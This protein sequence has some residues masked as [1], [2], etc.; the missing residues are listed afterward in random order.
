MS[1]KVF[2]LIE[3]V[4]LGGLVVFVMYIG[5][6]FKGRD[7]APTLQP[8]ATP[9]PV[10]T[11]K[12]A[13]TLTATSD[14]PAETTIPSPT[15]TTP[16]ITQPAGL[17]AFESNRDGNSEIY[18]VDAGNAFPI[19]LTDNPA[20]D[21]APLWSPDGSR[22]AFFSTRT[23]WLEI[24]A[25]NADGSNLKQ[26]TKT[27]GTNTAYSYPLSW[28]P[29]GERILALRGRVWQ[30]GQQPRPGSLD[31]IR[32]NGSGATTLYQNKDTY[33]W[34]PSWSPD[35][36]YVAL[37]M[38][39]P[40][41]E[42][43]LYLGRPE[44]TPFSLNRFTSNSCYNYTWSPDSKLTCYAGDRLAIVNPDGTGG[45]SLISF[46][47][48]YP[49]AILWL[50][51]GDFMLYVASNFNAPKLKVYVVNDDGSD[52]REVLLDAEMM[53]GSALSLSPD[54]QWLAYNSK[55]DDQ[56]NIYIVN[57]Y[58]TYQHA[59][60]TINAGDNLSPQWQP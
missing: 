21:Y 39:G 44:E 4:L 35:G 55:A 22:L 48:S 53:E 10:K 6:A 18:V 30:V 43:Q 47:S 13:P 7:P 34:Q 46:T 17:I 11:A 5:G 1:Q 32:A 26:L 14:H 16:A 37:I 52:R 49:T 25:M 42:S 15:P 24:Y 41:Q 33:V 54:G 60:L 27:K 9:L 40:L 59:Q 23:G 28:S 2:T 57:V 12:P 3:V 45:Q 20:E 56:A 36:N 8:T 58:D 50:P 29:D 51:T 19:N 31:L 38:A